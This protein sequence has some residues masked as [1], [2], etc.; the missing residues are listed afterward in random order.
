MRR[1][2]FDRNRLPLAVAVAVSGVV[3]PFLTWGY[4]K[5]IDERLVF[6]AF[7]DPILLGFNGVA[8]TVLA[9][10]AFYLPR[11]AAIGGLLEPGC[12]RWGRPET[13]RR[14]L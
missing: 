14:R 3:I 9:V 5:A 10:A 6:E 11:A 8:F 13:A 7:A 12:S 4:A 1:V 2:S